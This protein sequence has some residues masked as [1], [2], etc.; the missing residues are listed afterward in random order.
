MGQELKDEIKD[1]RVDFIGGEEQFARGI[2]CDNIECPHFIVEWET[3]KDA[4]RP[5]QDDDEREET[6]AFLPGN[7]P[8][9]CNEDRCR[10][11]H[12]YRSPI[13]KI[14]CCKCTIL[15][16]SPPHWPRDLHYRPT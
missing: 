3:I 14:R 8:A 7:A 12:V 13:I 1:G 2:A 11:S 16:A 10:I 15:S 6:E 5:G 4:K 9:R